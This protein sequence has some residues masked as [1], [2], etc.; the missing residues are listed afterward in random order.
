[1]LKV[2]NGSLTLGEA[3][4]LLKLCS[5]QVKRLRKRSKFEGLKGLIHQRVHQ[6][7]NEISQEEID[8]IIGLRQKV[9]CTFNVL[10]FQDVLREKH[11]VKRSYEFLRKLLIENKLYRSERKKKI[12]KRHRKRFEAPSAGMLVQRDTSIHMWL[13][14]TLKPWK[15]ILDIDDHSRKIVGSYFSEHDDVLSNML[16]A[17]ETMSTHGI[18]T[19]YYM[20]NNAIYNPIRRLP[21]QYDFF[22]YRNVE[23]DKKET[24]PQFKRAL[25]EMGIECIHSTPYE[26]QGKGKVERIFRFMQDRLVNEM[27]V[28]KVKTIE[29]G[30][31][32]LKK[33]VDWYNHCHVHSITKMIPNERY[34][35][36]NSFR[37][38][39]QTTKLE[40]IFCLKYERKVNADNTIQ[41]EG[42]TYQIEPNEYR[43][44]Y[45]RA[46]VE[47]RIYL[48]QILRITH[49][50]RVIGEYKYKY[51]NN[52]KLTPGGDILAWELW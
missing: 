37:K 1:L 6:S 12:R 16:V 11:G 52:N 44:S 25:K 7:V 31:K 13:E 20:D 18:P 36:N 10:H 35:K 41:F 24:L 45:A 23:R 46:Q 29:E 40:E 17:W 32:Y 33:W 15:L 2:E 8:Q 14:G 50:N 38:L 39:P 30:N 5:R 21:K 27:K 47:V 9:Y 42:K 48:N 51:K 26:P 49:H 43:I 34:L 19:A 22:R 28:A 4:K 3:G